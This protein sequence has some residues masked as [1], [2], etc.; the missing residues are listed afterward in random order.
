MV[1]WNLSMY[2]HRDLP[3]KVD[4]IDL[5]LP[6]EEDKKEVA[7]LTSLFSL[8]KGATTGKWDFKFTWKF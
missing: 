5:D 4:K 8:L 1:E 2:I 3:D 7:I 6:K